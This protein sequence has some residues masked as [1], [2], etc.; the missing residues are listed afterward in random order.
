M[1]LVH[2]TIIWFYPFDI[3]KLF[4]LYIRSY[5][6]NNSKFECCKY[7]ISTSY[8][9]SIMYF[10]EW[11]WTK[12]WYEFENRGWIFMTVRQEFNRDIWRQTI[13]ALSFGWAKDVW[14][15]HFGSMFLIIRFLD[16]LKLAPF[17]ALLDVNSS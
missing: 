8:S 11:F 2:N 9:F 10:F 14:N 12:V 3:F 4:F 5:G 15:I 17:C 1:K 13:M 6:H 16:F 7:P